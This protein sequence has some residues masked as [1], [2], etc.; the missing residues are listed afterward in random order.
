M[1]IDFRLNLKQ[2]KQEDLLQRS[3]GSLAKYSVP[4]KYKIG[5]TLELLIEYN[6]LLE[7]KYKQ[8]ITIELSILFKLDKD[9]TIWEYCKPSL[10][11]R[12]IGKQQII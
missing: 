5:G 12:D 1:L 7:N 9:E 11:L 3:K 4:S 6:D 2:M 10:T 8:K